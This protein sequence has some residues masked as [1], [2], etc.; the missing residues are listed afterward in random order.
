[1]GYGA[2]KLVEDFV[3]N[4]KHIDK[5]YYI[6]FAAKPDRFDSHKIRQA[7]KAYYQRPPKILGVLVWY[8][9]NA[10]GQFEFVPELSSPPDVPLDPSV[11]SEKA[12]DALP[13]VMSKGKQM[14][15]LLS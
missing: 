9:N 1:M 10:T 7:I 13:T 8:V 2:L 14:N 3:N 12:E 5:P 11:L 15:V 6:V 4:M